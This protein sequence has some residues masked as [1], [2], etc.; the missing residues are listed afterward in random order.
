MK[1]LHVI[2]GLNVGGAESMLLRLIM[3]DISSTTH[4]V[5]SLT[6]LGAIGESLRA[7]GVKVYVLGSRSIFSVFNV[8]VELTNLIREHKPDVIQTWMYHADLL[9][10]L[11]SCFA[12]NRNISWGIRRTAL[13]RN[14][15]PGTFFIMKVCALLSYWI[16]RR[17]ICNA[18]A[19]RQAHIAAGYKAKHI[20]VIPNGFDFS[21]YTDILAKRTLVRQSCRYSDEDLVIGSVSRFHSIKGQNI[22]VKAAS[23][24]VRAHPEVKFLLVGRNCDENNNELVG[25]LAKYGLLNSFVLL[26]ERNDV[27]ACLSAMDIFCMPSLS[28][29]FPNCLAEAMAVGLPCVA[30]DVGEVSSLTGGTVVIVSSGSEIDLVEGLLKVIILSK[31]QR[32]K[33]GVEAKNRVISEFSIEKARDR[34]MDV[35]EQIISEVL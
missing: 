15:S 32:L 24:V 19:A 29:G 26:G 30:T 18:Q 3:A 22:F 17:I 27:P 23:I 14:D 13:T 7:R 1:I 33:M 25:C 4:T 35:Y 28:E 12:G 31:E 8:L 5:I 9:G 21:C 20:V 11:A 34:F 6:T 2:V 10:G 16:P